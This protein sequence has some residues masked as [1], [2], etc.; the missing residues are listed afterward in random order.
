[1]VNLVS[2]RPRLR[3]DA[4]PAGNDAGRHRNG[5]PCA[6]LETAPLVGDSRNRPFVCPIRRTRFSFAA[7]PN[8]RWNQE[9][10]KSYRVEIKTHLRVEL[11]EPRHRPG[12]GFALATGE[13][14]LARRALIKQLDGN[15]SCVPGCRQL[16]GPGYSGGALLF[17]ARSPA[18]RSGFSHRCL[19]AVKVAPVLLPPRS[20]TAPTGQRSGGSLLPAA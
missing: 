20:D 1:M 7:I 18:E 14:K 3:V 16:Q 5:G 10:G 6:I 17:Q 13:T 19:F 2:G 8:C 4:P 15:L 9:P 11:A 12:R